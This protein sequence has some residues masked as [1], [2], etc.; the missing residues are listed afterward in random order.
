MQLELDQ[1]Q[2]TVLR[3]R[4]MPYVGAYL[5][6][7][8]DDADQAR[9]MLRRLIPYVTTAADWQG[10]DA[11]AWLNIVFT[12][13]GLRA[14]GL[15]RDILD[16]FPREFREPM[17]TRKEFLGDLGDSDP[18]NWDLPGRGRF[19]VG[20]LLMAPDQAAFDAKLAIG[21]GA[22]ADLDG[23]TRVDRLDI[24]TPENLREHF[25]F[26]DGISR[27]FIEGQGGEPKPGQAVTK[28]G[29]FLLGYVNELGHVATGPGPQALWRNGTY[30]SIRKLHQNVAMFRRFLKD[31][32]Q[33][34]DGEEL[35]AAKMVGRWRSGCPLAL[36]P[37]KDTPRDPARLNDFAYR[38]DDPDG[39]KTPPGSHIRRVNPRDA[40]T[41][42]IVDARLHRLL[43]RGA[44]YGP[45]LPEGVLDDDG[46]PRG[47]VLAFVNADPG[48]Q[49]EFVQSQWI[50]DGNFISAGTDQDPIAG[51][52]VTDSDFAYPARPV[53]RRLRGLPAF[54]VTRGG[55]HVFLPGISGLRHLAGATAG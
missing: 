30:L 6:Y 19:D 37:D 54:V 31:H 17:R 46:V 44:A 5:L 11:G 26:V 34:A 8:I 28:A 32:A 38:D 20:L 21:H 24:R 29:E 48:R 50:N 43:R 22:Q 7:Q 16:G 52:H 12:H 25:G 9:R 53:R 4:P 55:E 39:R 13:P 10:P 49:F 36:S 35:L 3:D 27:P 45:M 2:G 51:S 40:L 42:T 15:P 41:D 33:D 18:G 1:I 14:L 23:I 47:A